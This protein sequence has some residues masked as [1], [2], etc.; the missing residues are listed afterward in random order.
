MEE[1]MEK[2]EQI[3]E[4]AVNNMLSTETVK[5]S[6]LP[7]VILGVATLGVG[8]LIYKGIKYIKNK[9]KYTEITPENV[10]N[11]SN[12]EENPEESEED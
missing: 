2:V 6:T 4:E 3:S 1:N 5:S 9:N 12:L 7:V 10:R 11:F 8:F